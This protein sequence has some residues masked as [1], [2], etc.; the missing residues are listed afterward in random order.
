LHGGLKDFL[1]RDLLDQRIIAKLLNQQL[2]F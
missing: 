2:G 1:V